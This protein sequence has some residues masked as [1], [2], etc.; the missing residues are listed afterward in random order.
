MDRENASDL[1]AFLAD[2]QGA[3]FRAELRQSWGF[4][5]LHSARSSGD[6]SSGSAFAS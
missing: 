4:P 3:Q 2:R 5:S 6:S 1:L